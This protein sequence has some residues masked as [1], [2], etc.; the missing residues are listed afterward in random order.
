M[1]PWREKSWSPY[2]VGT[3][4]GVLSWIAFASAD[5]P[6]GI[7]SAFENTASIVARS[8]AP[9]SASL[10]MLQNAREAPPKIDWEWTLVVGVFLGAYLSS[11]LSGDRAHE[12]VP[13]IW[14]A[15]FGASRPKR[16]VGAFAGGVLL[17]FGARL[18]QGCTSGHGISGVLQLAVSSVTFLFVFFLVGIITAK[19]LYGGT[20]RHA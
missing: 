19:L 18:A 9:E 20:A 11:R 4:I 1:S 15:R 5:H 17:I 10:E 12:P 6:L 3:L 2:I 7:T 8:L 16:F 13:N 14:R